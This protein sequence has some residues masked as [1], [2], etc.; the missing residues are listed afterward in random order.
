M[1]QASGNKCSS[2]AM[3]RAIT[4]PDPEKVAPLSPSLALST[5][6]QAGKGWRGL[7]FRV[8]LREALAADNAEGRE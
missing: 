7:R 5:D 8:Y 2:P 4:C 3:R 6:G 1:G